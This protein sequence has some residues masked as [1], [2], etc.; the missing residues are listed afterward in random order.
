MPRTRASFLKLVTFLKCAPYCNLQIFRNLS[1]LDSWAHVYTD[2][3][4]I[5]HRIKLGLG[6]L[7][8]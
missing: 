4:N 2:K 5:T 6:P 8:L 7:G 3:F 1:D